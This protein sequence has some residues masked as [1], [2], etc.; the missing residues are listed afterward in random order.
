[1]VGGAPWLHQKELDPGF[2]LVGIVATNPAWHPIICR[3]VRAEFKRSPAYALNG[4]GG[5]PPAYARHVAWI[6][7]L[8][9]ER[10]AVTEMGIHDGER[11]AAKL[12]LGVASIVLGETFQRSADAAL[13]RRY[14]RAKDSSERASI[15]LRGRSPLQPWLDDREL[16]SMFAWRRG[17]HTMMLLPMGEFLALVAVLYGTEPLGI[18]ITSDHDLTQTMGDGGAAWV[19]AP[20]LRR[21]VGP[22]SVPEMLVDMRKDPPTG[23]L[24]DLSARLQAIPPPPP[25]HV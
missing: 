3:S 5:V 8:P 25:V 18:R 2:V 11:F 16:L 9:P 23:P 12:G 17:C 7:S 1:M 4:A 19:I 22:F 14:M 6:E 10:T 20:A 15:G 21:C 24:A 13:L